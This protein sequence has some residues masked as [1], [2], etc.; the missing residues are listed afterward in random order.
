[1]TGEPINLHDLPRLGIQQR[2]IPSYRVPFFDL[3]S[4]SFPA[5][6]A[7]FAGQPR[8]QEMIEPGRPKSAEYFLADNQHLFSGSLYLCRQRNFL[9]WLEEWQPQALVVEANPRYLNT[10]AAVHWMHQRRRPVIG[11]GLGSPPLVG[12]LSP[13]KRL[14]RRF[15]L[16]Q[17]DALIAYSRQGAAGYAALGIPAERIFV[18]PNAAVPRPDRE[19]VARP[20]LPAGEPPVVLFVGRLQARKRL[21][22][23]IQA[24]AG[25]PPALQP[26]LWIVGDGPESDALKILAQQIYPQIV[27]FGARHGDELD[28]LFR[29]ADLFVLPGTGGLAV[30]QA[31]SFALPVIVAEADGTQADLVRPQNG[32]LIPPGQPDAL[33]VALREAL[34]SPL[35]LWAMGLESHRVVRE[36]INLEAMAAGFVKAVSYACSDCR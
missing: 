28:D 1:M 31:M 5:G 32:W 20:A 34:A 22:T 18:A 29:R 35:R 16:S 26:R 7:V 6:T 19:V 21:D 12:I 15:F 4:A 24:C 17:F 10:P 13:V 9:A 25:L 36:E 27:F 2:V 11:W 33:A 30:Q 14:A 8:P 3:L 23:L